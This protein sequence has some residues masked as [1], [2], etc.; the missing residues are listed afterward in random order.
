MSD[1]QQEWIFKISFLIFVV[2][3]LGV[4]NAVWGTPGLIA[5]LILTVVANIILRKKL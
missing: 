3:T 1:F 5:M 4:I 2:T